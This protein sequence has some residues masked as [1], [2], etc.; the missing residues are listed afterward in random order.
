MINPGED[1]QTFQHNGAAA[2]FQYKIRVKCGENDYGSMCNKH[3]R[4]RDDY[5]GHFVC[6]QNGNK[7]CMEGWMG[8]DCVQ[9]N[10]RTVHAIRYRDISATEIRSSNFCLKITSIYDPDTLKYF[11]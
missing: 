3:C 9:G 2:S 8:E 10:C 4:P 11:L 1:S 6:D 5:F 7:A